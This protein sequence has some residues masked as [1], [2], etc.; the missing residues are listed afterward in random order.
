MKTNFTSV[1][2]STLL[3]LVITQPATAQEETDITGYANIWVTLQA[4]PGE[5]G[6][7]CATTSATGLKTWKEKV[8]FQQTIP[9]GSLFETN[10]IIYYVFARPAD[11]YTFAG[12]YEDTD[13]NGIFDIDT[14]QFL[15]DKTEYMMMSLLDEEA[16][17]YATQAEAKNGTKPTAPQQAVFAN[18]TRGATIGISYYQGEDLA[19]C[20]SVFCDKPVNEPGDVITVRALPTDGFQFEYWESESLLGNIISRENPYTFTVQGGEHLYAYF[21][22]ING[23]QVELPEEGGFRVIFLNAPWVMTEE[24]MRAGT[25]II[26]LSLD[27][28]THTDDGKVYL[29]MSKEDTM[30]DVGQQ[31]G[32]P[33]IVYGRGTARFAYK[34]LYGIARDMDPLVKWSGNKGATVKGENLYVYTFHEDAGAFV[35]IGNTDQILNPDAPT[36]VNV[37]AN[38][39]YITVSAFD[40]VDAQGIISPIIGLSPETF[41]QAM[42]GIEETRPSAMLSPSAVYDL[43]GRRITHVKSANGQLPKGL[44]IIDRRKVFIK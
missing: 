20:G 35:T 16:T 39:A 33:T 34:M 2:I 28:L 26:V 29:D 22:A 15:S 6:R 9:V 44:Y 11:G 31:N 21:T 5:G 32:C 37:P 12:W 41:D 10:F 8:D 25:H 30:I 13:G 1:L 3:T 24:T 7:V 19:N 40:L 17:L 36:Q 23:P 43:Q 38:Q 18:F 14:D 4:V 42:A 27:D